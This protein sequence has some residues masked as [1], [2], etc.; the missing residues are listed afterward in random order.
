MKIVF[1]ADGPWAHN[2]FRKIRSGGHRIV[3]IVLRYETRD[4]VLQ[5]LAEEAGIKVTWHK[6][7]NS[8]EF[9]DRLRK[10]GA[11]IGVSLAFNQIMRRNLMDLFP[12]G[13]INVHA[14]KL[15]EFRGRNILN[16]ALIN[17]VPEIG[18]TCH[19]ID[20]G[21]DTGGIIRQA[22]FPVTDEDDYGS[23]LEKAFELCPAVLT[24]ALKDIENGK[25]QVTPQPQ[26]GSYCVGRQDGD[27]FVDWTHGARRV[28]NL[29]RAITRPGPGARTW[30]RKKG[31]LEE[32]IIW[33][34]SPCR[35]YP[36]C[37]G[38]D[39]SVVGHSESQKPLVRTN[40]ELVELQDYARLDGSEPRLRIGDRLGIGHDMLNLLVRA[41]APEIVRSIEGDLPQESD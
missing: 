7:V 39:G 9:C 34:V 10:T 3:L 28:F 19:Y 26:E 27:E 22:V 29:V 30:L 1:F 13:I 25:E 18:V 6:K 4:P 17:D 32:L 15:P 5:V 12:K 23:I 38:V 35:E 8:A 21:I 36:H 33:K 24:D 20:V 41:K 40:G 14:G 31:D 16:W 37:I 2:A 11:E